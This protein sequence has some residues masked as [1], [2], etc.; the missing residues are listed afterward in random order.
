MFS[1]GAVP[2]IYLDRQ[3]V[4]NRKDI[5]ALQNPAKPPQGRT[6]LAR[7]VCAFL[8]RRGATK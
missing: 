8:S 2:K 7:K 6:P 5:S 1:V 3:A 4:D